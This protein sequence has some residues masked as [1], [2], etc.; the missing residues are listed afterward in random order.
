MVTE[1][2]KQKHNIF[3][4]K[5]GPFKFCSLVVKSFT[6]KLIEN[7]TNRPQIIFEEFGCILQS[8]LFYSTTFYKIFIVY[9]QS[10]FFFAWIADW[11]LSHNY[12]KYNWF[13][14]INNYIL[15]QKYFFLSQ[16]F[17]TH[18]MDPIFITN[19][20]SCHMAEHLGYNAQVI[21]ITFLMLL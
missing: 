19:A 4:N 17:L 15:I 10:Q 9:I 3:L 7:F 13:V 1:V 18:Q 20:L 5:S 14:K 11:N 12:R 6:Q 2:K 8:F 16:I 21:W